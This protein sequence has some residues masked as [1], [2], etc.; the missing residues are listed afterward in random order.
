VLLIASAVT[1]LIFLLLIDS[2]YLFSDKS[3][4]V[5]LH[6]GQTFISALVIVSFLSGILLPFLFIALVKAGLIVYQQIFNKLTKY[7]TNLRFMRIAFLI[8]PAISFIL[9][10]AHP[11]NVIVIIFLTG[12]LFDRILFYIDFNPVNI[13]S[14][15]EEQL[16]NSGC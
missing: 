4:S 2:V 15:I 14:L 1:G 11:E 12:E 8:I 13:K 10:N 3:K 7:H 6:P 9:H 5:L 16:N